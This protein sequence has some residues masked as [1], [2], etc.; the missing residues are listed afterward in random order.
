MGTRHLICVVQNEEFKLANYGQYDGSPSWQGADIIEFLNSSFNKEIFSQKISLLK[1]YTDEQI[2]DFFEKSE[3][4][5]EMPIY[6]SRETGAKILPYIQ[7]AESEIPTIL[8]L[9]FSG[10]SQMC[11]W[12]YVIDLDK[13]TFEVFKGKNTSPLDKNNPLERFINQP[14]QVGKDK[15]YY[16]IKHLKTFNLS[17]LPSKDEFKK[18]FT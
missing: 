2:S 8:E 18:M 15:V 16:Q 9:E 14:I 4:T 5:D 13:D 10:D 11:E 12:A 7:N 17:E 3:I 6:F 1:P